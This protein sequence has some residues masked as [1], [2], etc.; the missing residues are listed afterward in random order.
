[1]RKDPIKK[2]LQRVQDLR[3]QGPSYETIAA[4]LELIQ[5]QPGIVVGNAAKVAAQWKEAELAVALQNAFDRLSED[6]LNDDPQCWG[7]IGIIKALHELAWQDARVYVQGGRTVQLEPVYGGKEDSAAPVRTASF[8]ALVQLPSVATATVMTMLA[9]LLA[10]P[11]TKVRAEAARASV[12]CPAELTYPLLRLKIRTGDTEPRVLG[13]CFDALLVLEPN[14]EMVDL[15][16]EYTRSDN[17]VLQAEALASLASSSI[18]VAVN[19]VTEVYPTLTDTQLRRVLLTAL[20]GSAAQEALDFLCAT[21]EMA[22]LQ[23]ASW[24]LEALKPKLH[25]EDLECR[26]FE[27]LKAR[28]DDELLRVY[29]A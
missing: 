2:S 28:Q 27:Q 16:L 8:Q 10:D 29:Q 18:P 19:A 5:T 23:E 14:N 12:Y 21:L 11:N 9:D 25:D 24:A 4:L 1:M 17:D 13:T 20:G 22:D 26:V 3:S 15:I 7:K 6:G